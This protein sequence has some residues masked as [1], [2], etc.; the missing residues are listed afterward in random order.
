MRSKDRCLQRTWLLEIIQYAYLYGV[1][2]K[3]SEIITKVNIWNFHTDINVLPTYPKQTEWVNKTMKCHSLTKKNNQ[4]SHWKAIRKTTNK[5]N[6]LWIR[7]G[8]KGKVQGHRSKG[9]S[10]WSNSKA[11]PI[12]GTCTGDWRDVVSNGWD[13][14]FQRTDKWPLGNTGQKT[15][16]ISFY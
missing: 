14:V 4:E 15:L 9:H 11:L 8:V 5:Q 13:N 6:N 1:Y 3:L 7:D 16:F 12:Q 10:Y 2:S